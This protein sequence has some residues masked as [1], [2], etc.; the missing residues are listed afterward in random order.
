MLHFK[1]AV[2]VGSF[3]MFGVPENYRGLAW[4]DVLD[5]IHIYHTSI[6]GNIIVR[7]QGYER[8]EVN[9]R[10]KKIAQHLF[11]ND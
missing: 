1:N 9:S 2:E 11:G 3:K 6:Q 5:G 7:E 4:A 10:Q 8:E